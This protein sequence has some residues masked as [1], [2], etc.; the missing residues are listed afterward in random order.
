MP[1]E[2][3]TTHQPTNL[4]IERHHIIPQAW[5]FTWTPAGAAPG[6]LWDPRT[7]DLCPTGHRN[8]HMIIVAMMKKLTIPRRNTKEYTIAKEALDRFVAA[9]GDLDFLRSKGEWGEA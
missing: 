1:C 2:A 5:Q 4:T 8:V 7:A 3:H 6:K 9:G